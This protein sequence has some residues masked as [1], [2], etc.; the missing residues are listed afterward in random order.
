MKCR[1][2][3]FKDSKK[4]N[5]DETTTRIRQILREKIHYTKH[6]QN[7]EDTSDYITWC[8]N[9]A[10]E[11]NAI[12]Y[13]TIA[14]MAYRSYGYPARYVEGY[15][16]SKDEAD[17]LSKNKKKTTVLT[18]D[19]AHAW[20][21]VYRSGIGWM[22]VELVP[23]MYIETY[24]SQKVEGKPSYQLKSKKDKSGINTEQGKSGNQKK[25]NQ[26]HEKSSVKIVVKHFI[27]GFIV[28]L[29]VLLLLYFIL[30]LQRM[31]RLSCWKKERKEE[32]SILDFTKTM[33]QLFILSKIPGDYSHPLELRSE[34]LLKYPQLYDMEYERV[35]SIIQKARFGGK[36]LR[37]HE[38]HTLKCFIDKISHLLWKNSNI[39]GK[40][41]L[42]YIYL[43]PKN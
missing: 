3:F 39:F 37:P 25:D 4:L 7:T 26:D 32:I 31:I 28:I 1:R 20:V 24:S 34:I 23:G 42:R 15:H 10:K 9:S 22:S 35:V 12:S 40:I 29:Y 16:L 38:E 41:L 8:L 6:P 14:V 36:N 27:T 33:E 18:T 13:A 43:I 11:G 17:Q 30:E 2:H 5:F 19:N 21:E